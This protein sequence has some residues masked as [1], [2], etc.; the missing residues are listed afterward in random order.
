MEA[1]THQHEEAANNFCIYETDED[2]LRLAEEK[3]LTLS[4]KIGRARL[5]QRNIYTKLFINSRVTICECLSANNTF[6]RMQ[7]NIECIRGAHLCVCDLGRHEKSSLP[8]FARQQ[9]RKGRRPGHP[10]ATDTR[11][12]N[13]NNNSKVYSDKKSY[14]H[15]R[16]RFIIK[17]V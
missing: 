1:E 15:A 7:R 12:N 16:I 17:T 11:T 3:C 10:P 8:E 9:Q 2:W 6:G 4:V 13:P 14:R 5:Y